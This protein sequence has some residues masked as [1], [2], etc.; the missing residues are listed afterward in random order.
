MDLRNRLVIVVGLG[1]SGVA[2]ARL[3]I[4]RGARVVAND[5]ASLGA[6]SEGA[7][8]LASEGAALVVGGHDEAPW[9][10]ADLVVISPGVPAFPALDIVKRRG[11]EIIS[12]LELGFRFADSS[13]RI[14]A[15]GGTNGKSTTTSLVAAMLDASGQRVFAGGNL[16]TP[17]CEAIG[18][19]FDSL[20]IEVSSFQAERLSLFRPSVGALLNLSDDHL[21]RYTSFEDYV[22]AK[23]NIFARQTADDLAVVPSGDARVLEQARRGQGRVVSFGPG[24]DVEV[25][26]NHIESHGDNS[27]YSLSGFKLEGEHNLANACA[28]VAVALGAGATQVGIARA[29]EGFEALSH[30]TRLVREVAN[31]RYY[32][33]SKGTN[34]GASVAAL[35]GMRE[36]RTVLIAG[37]RDKFGSYE[38]LA[39]AL[40]EKGRALVVLGEAA[41]R[42]EESVRGIVEVVH[43]SSM[44]DAVVKAATL[45]RPGD[46][47]LLSPAC[48]SFDMFHSFAERGDAFI[49]AVE[50]L[51][52]G[53]ESA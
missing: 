29:L 53:R 26:G 23:G 6:L 38:P 31:I 24:G 36:E 35:L 41:F 3:C 48:S 33:D 12:E 11:I 44:H 27:R 19:N 16:G 39:K 8:A 15:I 37:G 47:V 5:K 46:A 2:A 18:E 51:E 49:R 28:A 32:D 40:A 10:E 50:A 7:R 52:S 1:K 34:V 4:S 25:V 43:A 30:R 22:A 45:A 17:L 42:I 13:S 21:D 14:V 9:A 20:V